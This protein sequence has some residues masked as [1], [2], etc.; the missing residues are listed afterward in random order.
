MSFDPHP[1]DNLTLS[2]L[3]FPGYSILLPSFTNKVTR[4]RE[5]KTPPDHTMWGCW[6]F[7]AS[8]EPGNSQVQFICLLRGIV[9]QQWQV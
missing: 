1:A 5:K 4:F 8:F 2:H 7:K 3:I 6:D 9:P